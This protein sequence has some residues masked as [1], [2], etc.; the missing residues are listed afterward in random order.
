MEEIEV[1]TSIYGDCI[2]I[3]N[4]HEFSMRFLPFIGDEN[5]KAFLL[6]DMDFI[7]PPEYPQSPPAFKVIKQKGLGEENLQ[8]FINQLTKM[9]DMPIIIV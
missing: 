3:K 4:D 6:V 7:L 9:Y 1:L 5:D 8:I 2:S